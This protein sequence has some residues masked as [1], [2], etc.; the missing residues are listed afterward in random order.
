MSEEAIKHLKEAVK[1]DPGFAIAF[2]DLG[3]AYYLMGEADEAIR[4]FEAAIRIKPDYPLA[5]E[6]LRA[7]Q[8][9]RQEG[10]KTP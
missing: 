8:M 6:N 10:L 3:Y 5:I 7:A 2:N 1:L 4:D 9:L